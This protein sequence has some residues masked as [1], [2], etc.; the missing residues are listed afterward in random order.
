MLF[1]ANFS[2]ATFA[3]SDSA[4]SDQGVA[5]DTSNSDSHPPPAITVEE[6]NTPTAVVQST[7][8]D[9]KT[10]QSQKQSFTSETQVTVS[11]R[12]LANIVSAANWNFWT[13]VL[14][15]TKLAYTGVGFV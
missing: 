14:A 2:E 6:A 11:K 15:S 1:E 3:A 7:T 4:V 12:I 13:N 9:I 8:E 5:G 10:E